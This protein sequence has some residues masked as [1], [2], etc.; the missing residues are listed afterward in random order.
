[1]AHDAAL[2]ALRAARAEREAAVNALTS[3]TTDTQPTVQ[4]TPGPTVP[5]SSDA[6]GPTP[7]LSPAGSSLSGYTARM[8]FTS[9][10][11]GAGNDDDVTPRN[12]VETLSSS[13]TTTTT[14]G[15]PSTL[16]PS[17]TSGQSA[18]SSA[19][20]QTLR[21][22]FTG[23]DDD[24]D[25]LMK[26]LIRRAS[27]KD[28]D[29]EEEEVD[30]DDR[31]VRDIIHAELPP[32]PSAA[33]AVV[34]S[35][36][37]QSQSRWRQRPTTSDPPSSRVDPSPTTST[38]TTPAQRQH[39][40]KK[41]SPGV[42]LTAEQLGGAAS[43]RRNSTGAVEPRRFAATSSPRSPVN[44]SAMRSP[45]QIPVSS[46]VTPNSSVFPGRPLPPA[47]SQIPAR[48]LNVAKPSTNTDAKLHHNAQT[49]FFVEVARF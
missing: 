39:F 23:T 5:P 32:P 31:F 8:S 10:D 33:A 41:T 44:L 9:S 16:S 49:Q 14:R 40:I 20:G 48:S 22:N 11:T 28:D 47:P 35:V 27:L 29:E 45:I 46:N 24:D 34:S 18:S 12:S 38:R 1:M 25:E 30:V 4:A 7:G 15:N 36:Q 13:S 21:V 26:Q 3:S 19:S 17:L 37:Q 43:L 42:P 2:K 6:V